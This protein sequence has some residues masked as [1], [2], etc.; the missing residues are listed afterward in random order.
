MSRQKIELAELPI[1]PS[2]AAFISGTH[3]EQPPSIS[4]ALR[5]D[6]A[7][8]LTHAKGS[9]SSGYCAAPWLGSSKFADK[10]LHASPEALENLLACRSFSMFEIESLAL[11]IDLNKNYFKPGL[12]SHLKTFLA[13]HFVASSLGRELMA[14]CR[15]LTGEYRS[16]MR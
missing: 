1:H 2:R 16:R 15:Q 3:L 7:T 4:L 11:Q 13:K 14:R 10:V 12:Q 6:F 5:Y 8:L 9:L